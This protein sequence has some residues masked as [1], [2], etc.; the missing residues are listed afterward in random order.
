LSVSLATD[1]GFSTMTSRIRR[2]Y[3]MANES[4]KTGV[5]G[6]S[7]QM[8]ED[9]AEDAITEY[10]TE[11]SKAL[12]KI[13][14]ETQT[15]HQIKHEREFNLVM[16]AIIVLN[17]FLIAIEIDWGPATEA[18]LENRIGWIV[19]D[20][21]FTIIFVSEICVRLYWERWR[22]P[23]SLWNWFDVC[24]VVSA[25]VDVLILSFYSGKKGLHLL[26]VLRIA[27]LLR[28][29]RMVKLVRALQGIY[30]MVKAFAQAMKAMCFLCS[31]M[32]FGVLLYAIVAANM[33]GRNSAFDGVMIYDDTV[34][35]RFG[36]VAR[37][38]YSLF[39]L[40]TLEGWD[41]VVR[42]LVEAQPLSI[43]FFGSFIVIFT[44]GMLNMIVALVV[45]KTMEQTRQMRELENRRE[46]RKTRAELK[47]V[48]GVFHQ[49]DDNS[50]ESLTLP[51]LKDAIEKNPVVAK[52]LKD[53][54]IPSENVKE[55][56]NIL[57]WDGSGEIQ[58]K[59]FLEGIRKVQAE[60][61]SS[62]DAALVYSS[63]RGMLKRMSR[64]QDIAKKMEE[65]V[66]NQDK[67][68]HKLMMEVQSLRSNRAAPFF[69]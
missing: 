23:C 34:Y 42:P 63:V 41:Q 54:G 59:E 22:W 58:I 36:T 39:E 18:P 24:V 15:E 50:D 44:F 14:T 64:L 55:L 8:T 69:K 1:K 2:W 62:K 47:R 7:Y 25:L 57:D 38:M 37:S 68:T 33:I 66:Q 52:H 19:L 30:V 4:I 32:V 46:A 12:R 35:V 51:E 45:E 10:R 27:R 29:N 13:T 26:T 16:G 20:I 61:P 43:F 3:E 60:L 53:M 65:R 67:L 11:S 31:M 48:I 5:L 21:I 17:I 56:F 40:I 9:A 28:L 6:E 49:A